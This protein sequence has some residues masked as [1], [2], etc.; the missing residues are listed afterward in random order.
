MT[1]RMAKRR[2]NGKRVGGS[3]TRGD[4]IETKRTWGWE[5]WTRKIMTGRGGKGGKGETV[6]EVVERRRKKGFSEPCQEEV[7][8]GETGYCHPPIG[9]KG[10]TGR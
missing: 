2:Y 7:K 9:G 6:E 3:E 8:R 1:M 4:F 10:A 5:R